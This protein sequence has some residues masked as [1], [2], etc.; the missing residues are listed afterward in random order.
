MTNLCKGDR[1]LISE[2][3]EVSEVLEPKFGPE[4]KYLVR[5]TDANG[6]QYELAFPRGSLHFPDEDDVPVISIG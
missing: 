3:F 5:V 2:E 4:P 6:D 1:V